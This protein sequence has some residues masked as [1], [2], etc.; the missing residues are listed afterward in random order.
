[1]GNSK[2]LKELA[3]DLGGGGKGLVAPLLTRN[4]RAGQQALG[5]RY[6]ARF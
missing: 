5:R 1:M 6:E 4:V 2:Q 3:N